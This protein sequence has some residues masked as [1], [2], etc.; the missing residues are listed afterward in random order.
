[1]LTYARYE[2]DKMKYYYAVA[3]FDSA[4]TAK[5]VYEQCDGV[6]LC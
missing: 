2:A 1:M 6:E 3:R 5:A 4:R